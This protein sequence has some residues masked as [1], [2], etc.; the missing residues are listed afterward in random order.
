MFTRLLALLSCSSVFV[1][2]LAYLRAGVVLREAEVQTRLHTLCVA[3]CSVAA[4]EGRQ[5]CA[6]GRHCLKYPLALHGYFSHGLHAFALCYSRAP[7]SLERPLSPAFGFA[8]T[9]SRAQAANPSLPVFVWNSGLPRSCRSRGGYIMPRRLP[10][11]GRLAFLSV[12]Q[13]GV[14]LRAAARARAYLR[15]KLPGNFRKS[16]GSPPV[17]PKPFGNR[18]DRCGVVATCAAW[19]LPPPTSTPPSGPRGRAECVCVCVANFLGHRTA[20]SCTQV[21]PGGAFA[22]PLATG[23]VLKVSHLARGCVSHRRFDPKTH[24]FANPTLIDSRSRA[25]EIRGTRMNT[26]N[27]PLAHM[28]PL[29]RGHK[30]P[31]RPRRGRGVAYSL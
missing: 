18:P 8:L 23:N 3:S 9:S 12:A 21:P 13:S 26:D 29:W 5:R 14:H 20:Q 22:E 16:W 11:S 28:E 2:G 10:T 27:H 30:H 17:A 4:G 31:P 1:V 7:Q 6:Q 24:P 15:V 25:G 19:M